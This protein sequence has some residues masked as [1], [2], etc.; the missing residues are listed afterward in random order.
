MPTVLD[1]CFGEVGSHAAR[2]AGFRCESEATDT[3]FVP[4][5]AGE[6]TSA[7]QSVALAALYEQFLKVPVALP[8]AS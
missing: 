2:A 1:T 5:A 3:L 7:A 4:V 8:T 6:Q